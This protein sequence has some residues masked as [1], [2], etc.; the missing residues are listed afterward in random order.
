LDLLDDYGS[1]MPDH[2]LGADEMALI[3]AWTRRVWR[4]GWGRRQ[5]ITTTFA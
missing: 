4:A 5:R 1:G 2:A 3:D